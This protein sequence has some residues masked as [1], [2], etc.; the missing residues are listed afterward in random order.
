MADLYLLHLLLIC[1]PF[2]FVIFQLCNAIL[3]FIFSAQFFPLLFNEVPI[4][5]CSLF[6][7]VTWNDPTLVSNL[8][9]SSSYHK[10][11]DL[12]RLY[13]THLESLDF[14][15]QRSIKRV[16]S[17]LWDESSL[18]HLSLLLS[19]SWIP[20]PILLFKL[21][22]QFVL[23]PHLLSSKFQNISFCFSLLSSLPSLSS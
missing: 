12:F 11:V 9:H 23:L 13:P 20:H 10:N 8:D 14:C 15:L 19:P 3:P 18:L 16:G 22:S 17:T 21:S 5:F 4:H 2:A 7:S 1:H 6:L